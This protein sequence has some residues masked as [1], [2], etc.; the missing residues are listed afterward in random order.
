ME[1]DN[2]L[3][4]TVVG[5]CNSNTNPYDMTKID[6]ISKLPETVIKADYFI[7]HLGN[8]KHKFV[9]GIDKGYHTFE[10]MDDSEVIEWQYRPSILNDFSVSEASILS[11]ANNQKI[12]HDFL[13]RY[14]NYDIGI[15]KMYS[16][17][18]K[19][20]VSFEYFAG[21][22]KLSFENLQIEIDLTLENAGY[23]TVFE[24]KNSK[25]NRWTENFNIYQLYN[26]FRY[27]YNLKQNNKLGIEKLTACYLIRQKNKGNSIIR[28]YNYTFENPLDITSVKLLKKREYHLKKKE[29]EDE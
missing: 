4:K 15:P 27:Y 2:K 11:L 17:E 1:F 29:F 19:R 26:P 7:V 8:G 9:K 28:L 5:K 21:N 20:G 12:L 23:V 16:S 24:G 13:Y 25:L 22:E 14:Q 6:D 10:K 18:R 3:V